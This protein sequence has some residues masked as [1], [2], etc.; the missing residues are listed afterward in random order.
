MILASR[1]SIKEYKGLFLLRSLTW[2]FVIGM[3]A[4][5]CHSRLEKTWIALQRQYNSMMSYVWRHWEAHCIAILFVSSIFYYRG[6]QAERNVSFCTHTLLNLLLKQSVLHVS[7]LFFQKTKSLLQVPFSAFF[8]S[9]IYDLCSLFAF[10]WDRKP[11]RHTLRGMEWNKQ[12]RKSLPN[13]MQMSQFPE[14]L[15]SGAEI[16][17]HWTKEAKSKEKVMILNREIFSAQSKV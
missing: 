1:N 12:E 10:G 16:F 9:K 7:L 11:R 13:I 2:H 17:V 5:C 4:R 6:R 15:L 3:R 8:Y 14:T